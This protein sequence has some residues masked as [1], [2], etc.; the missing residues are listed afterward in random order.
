MSNENSSTLAASAR[1]NRTRVRP[2]VWWGAGAI[3][4]VLTVLTVTVPAALADDF[5]SPDTAEVARSATHRSLVGLDVRSPDTIELSRRKPTSSTG[6][7][8]SPDRQ[9]FGRPIVKLVALPPVE[10]VRTINSGWSAWA[11]A[12]V[13]AGALLALM[14]AISGAFALMH[15]KVV[16][17][18]RAP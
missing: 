9:D 3:T 7:P 12:G 11:G 16:K 17:P 14:L 15:W 6:S 8:A 5:R 4:C 1:P 2:R 10:T 18:V 13:G